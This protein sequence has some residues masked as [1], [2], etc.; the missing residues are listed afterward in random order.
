MRCVYCKYNDG[1]VY[2]SIP[3]KYRCTITNEFHFGSDDCNVEFAPV[4]HGKWIN[5]ED[6][7]CYKCSICGEYATQEHGLNEPIFWK[8]CPNCGA[9]MDGEKV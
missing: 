8:Y 1:L 6:S 5:P 3:V 9:K 2:T 4:Q 7:T